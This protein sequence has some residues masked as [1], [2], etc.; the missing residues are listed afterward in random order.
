MGKKVSQNLRYI[1][2]VAF[3]SDLFERCMIDYDDFCALETKYADKFRPLFRYGK[4]CK[5]A[6]LPITQTEQEGRKPNGTEN[7]E[8]QTIKGPNT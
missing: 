4:P 8:N 3:L 2:A 6:T 5:N 7:P 1:V